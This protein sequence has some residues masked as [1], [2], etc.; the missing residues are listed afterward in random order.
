MAPDWDLIKGNPR[1]YTH[2]YN[3]FENKA[4]TKK[5]TNLMNHSVCLASYHVGKSVPDLSQGS[6][7]LLTGYKSHLLSETFLTPLFP[8]L[9][10]IR[11]YQNNFIREQSCSKI[12]ENKTEK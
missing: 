6:S 2:T 4:A 10:W 7:L 1:Y 8:Y 12:K 3:G 11:L 5:P 9:Q